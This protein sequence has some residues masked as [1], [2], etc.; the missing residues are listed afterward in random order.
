MADLILRES[1]FVNNKFYFS[2]GV[3]KQAMFTIV[4]E[5]F[6]GND[7]GLGRVNRLTCMVRNLAVDGTVLS[8]NLVG[9]VIGL[10]DGRVGVMSQ[11]PE[12]RGQLMTHENM[13]QCVVTL[14]EA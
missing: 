13:E 7:N 12:L 3:R 11:V 4:D 6:Q 10:G 2:Y 5:T 8:A 9:L 1:E 14:Y